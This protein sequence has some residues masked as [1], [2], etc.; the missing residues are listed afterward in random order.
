[1]AGSKLFEGIVYC[2]ALIWLKAVTTGM[3]QRQPPL[4]Q[5]HCTCVKSMSGF[6]LLKG[7]RVG[8]AQSYRY[9]ECVAAAFVDPSDNLVEKS[10]ESIKKR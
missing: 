8:T 4:M 5:V 3:S 7:S 2:C 1:M 9:P 10:G 6:L